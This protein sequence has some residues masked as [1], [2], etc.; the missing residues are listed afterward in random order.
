[1]TMQ[2]KLIALFNSRGQLR[3][4]DFRLGEVNIIS[5]S[6]NTG[7]SAVIDIVEYCLGNSEFNVPEGHIRTDVEWYAVLFQVNQF[8]VFIAKPKPE[9]SKSR[10]EGA[11]VEYG[12]VVSVPPYDRLRLNYIDSDIRRLISRL[13]RTSDEGVVFPEYQRQEQLK[14]SVEFTRYYLFQESSIIASP[15][16]LFYRQQEQ[17]VS[18]TIK[19]TLPYF[20]GIVND[21]DLVLR[22]KLETTQSDL[23]VVKAKIRQLDVSIERYKQAQREL[24]REAQE[25]GL[26]AQD[27]RA[28]DDEGVV[29]ELKRILSW[30]P[31]DIPIIQDDRAPVLQRQV[32][33]LRRRNSAIQE[34]ITAIELHIRDAEGYTNE[35]NE[36]LMRL[37][38]INIFEEPSDMFAN[39]CP[40]CYSPLAQSVPQSDAIRVALQELEQDLQVVRKEQPALREYLQTLQ[41]GKESLRKQIAETNAA[42]GRIFEEQRN[43]Q[44]LFQQVLNAN[45]LVN[46]TLGKIIQ[47]LTTA[48]SSDEI[49][50]IHQQEAETLEAVNQLKTAVSDDDI[51]LERNRVS[52]LLG[53]QMTEWGNR[54]GLLPKGVYHLDLQRLSVYVS[55]VN[56]S[57][58]M[59]QIGGGRNILGCHLITLL[60]LHRFFIEQR[61][62]VPSFVILDQPAQGYFPTKQ[63]YAALEVKTGEVSEETAELVNV[64]QMFGFLF[65]VCE[66]LS[67][68]IQI[69]VL[70]HANL[71]YDKKFKTA[72]IEPFWTPEN[73]LLPGHWK[74]IVSPSS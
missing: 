29:A 52:I 67:P 25:V 27:F 4:L 56:G 2:I 65:D 47:H 16:V 44:E 1:M 49:D 20:L 50:L 26:I 23:R 41:S 15:D 14:T 62:P 53:Q 31:S 57:T 39:L 35:V 18:Q 33:D 38:S 11:Y 10:Q 58:P 17:G 63:A 73:G 68:K 30:Q 45:A 46:R 51:E 40:L 32:N 70:E 60:T 5:G 54:L 66:Q 7:K 64:Q 71:E 22:R 37:E 6:N 12:S 55:T 42:I 72:Q 34:E 69:I 3:Q 61:R 74:S 8:Q 48:P 24:L 59:S 13:L 43:S 21:N 28:S 9:K 36:Q 19:D